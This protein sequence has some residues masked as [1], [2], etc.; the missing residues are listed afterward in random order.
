MLF[1]LPTSCLLLLAFLGKLASEGQAALDAMPCLKQLRPARQDPLGQMDRWLQKLLGLAAKAFCSILHAAARLRLHRWLSWL[2]SRKV[3]AM[4]L[5][6]QGLRRAVGMTGRACYRLL[7]LKRIGTAGC[8]MS[9]YAPAQLF[10]LC[11]PNA[12]QLGCEDQAAVPAVLAAEHMVARNALPSTS[13]AS[14]QVDQVAGVAAGSSAA[15][16]AE[17]SGAAAK[18]SRRAPRACANCGATQRPDGGRLR[19][20]ARCQRARYCSQ[21]CMAADWPTHRRVCAAPEEAAE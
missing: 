1:L 5:L 4:A 18:T 12:P 6:L 13:Q 20:C 7:T 11:I 19:K 2:P 8:A 21:E 3:L 15:A 17:G 14:R 16:T 9:A 10:C